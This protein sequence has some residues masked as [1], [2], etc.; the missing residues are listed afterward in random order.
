MRDYLRLKF[1]ELEYEIFTVIFLDTRHRIIR[2][3]ELFR[4]TI[5][6]ASVYPREVVK[7]ALQ[8]NAAATLFAH[9]QPSSVPEPSTADMAITRR[10]K[11]ALALVDIRVLD[12][13]IVTRESI[14]SLAERGLI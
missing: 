4:G 13:L 10:L 11:E 2:F 14:V 5:D 3:E 12:H 6:G 7:L 8:C 9:N 1:G